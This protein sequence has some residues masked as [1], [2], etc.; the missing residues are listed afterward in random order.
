[1]QETNSRYAD[2]ETNSG[3]AVQE[4]GSRP[5]EYDQAVSL[6]VLAGGASRRMGTDKADLHYDGQTFLERQIAKGRALGLTDILVSGYRGAACSARIVKDRIPGRGP[7]GGLEACLREA[8]CTRCLVLSVD[9]PLV[10]EEELHRLIRAALDQDAPAV[11]LSHGGKEEPLIGVYRSDLADEMER[12]IT[13]RKGSVFAFLRRIGYAVWESRA[14]D[15]FFNNINDPER[16]Y[17]VLR[18]RG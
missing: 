4:T 6:V 7:L 8:A 16:Y 10:P 15:P 18:K 17:E 2:P 12:E 5:S 1:M 11:I 9:V 13:E 14:A 3:C